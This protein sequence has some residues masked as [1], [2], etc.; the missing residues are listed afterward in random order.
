MREFTLQVDDIF[1]KG[2]RTDSRQERGLHTLEECLNYKPTEFGLIPYETVPDPIKSGEFST[3][4]ITI[5]P[6]FPQIFRG[7]NVTLVVSETKVWTVNESDW[8]LTLLGDGN[9]KFINAEDVLSATTIAAD[10]SGLWHFADWGNNWMLVNTSASIFQSGVHKL[11]PDDAS[12]VFCNNTIVIQT[13]AEFKGRTVIGGFT[14][15]TFWNND[16]N[17]MFTYWKQ[18]RTAGINIG[19]SIGTNYVMW[20]SIG[21]GDFPLWLMFHENAMKGNV[22][23]SSTVGYTQPKDPML[24]DMVR[25]N[26]FGFMPMNWQG[27]VLK[28]LPLGNNLI[29]YGDN[30]ISALTPIL[31]PVPTFGLRDISR[32]FGIISRGA[33]GGDERGHTLVNED[34][35]L[36]SLSPDLQLKRL[37]YRE[38]F[39]GFSS[40]ETTVNHD[41]DDNE[42]YIS[43]GS[44]S[45]VLTEVGLGEAAERII[46]LVTKDGV[47]SGVIETQGVATGQLIIDIGNF[48]T[49]AIKS[50]ENVHV[51]YF[52]SATVTVAVDYR[53]DRT[54]AFTR[55][56]FFPVNKEGM[57]F[58][59]ISGI[60]FKLIFKADAYGNVNNWNGFEFNVKFGDKRYK[61]GVGASA[62]TA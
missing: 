61:R 35:Y 58:P 39:T 48:G 14:S 43:D 56:A 29:V 7:R 62:I 6:P 9:G 3:H 30:G 5:N 24:L 2:L 4:S 42:F 1:K 26:Q 20:G 44:N 10:S 8:S 57:S 28:I 41:P 46:S 17:D 33:A 55:T 23:G 36:Y 60:D 27:T 49:A 51:N 13:I 54:S 31:E 52:G 50:I 37:G 53:Y 25:K 38:F 47:L 34:G 16:W 12:D 32:E 19:D 18:G 11:S 40:T 15:S 45:Y 22:K 59:K 21:G